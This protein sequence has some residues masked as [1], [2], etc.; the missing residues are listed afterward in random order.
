MG[1]DEAVA[2]I[3]AY[4]NIVDQYVPSNKVHTSKEDG[5]DYDWII[6]SACIEALTILEGDE[7]LR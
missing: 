3:K 1:I 5:R 2:K 6:K 4:E 7:G